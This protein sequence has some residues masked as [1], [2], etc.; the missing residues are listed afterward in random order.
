MINIYLIIQ[1]EKGVSTLRGMRRNDSITT[2]CEVM[3]GVHDINTCSSWLMY[4]FGSKNEEGFVSTAV[5]LGCP[6][7]TKM[8]DHITTAAIWQ[9][10]YMFPKIYKD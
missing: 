9:E 7:L 3:S 6:M 5:K 10:S 2:I 8:M 4:Y 1:Y